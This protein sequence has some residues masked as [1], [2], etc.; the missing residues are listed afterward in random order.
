MQMKLLDSLHL[1]WL[2]VK[3]LLRFSI[4][5]WPYRTRFILHDRCGTLLCVYKAIQGGL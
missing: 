3:N 1:F 5:R 4:T 2:G